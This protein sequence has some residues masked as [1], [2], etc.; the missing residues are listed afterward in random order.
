MQI[1]K[2]IYGLKQAPRAWFDRLAKTLQSFGFIASKCDPSL[3]INITPHATTYVLVYVDDIL[4]TGSSLFFSNSLKHL[5]HKEFA[6]KDLGLLKY[7]LG[8]EVSYNPDGSMHLSQRKYIQD[9]LVKANMHKAKPINTPMV[10]GL[11]LTKQGA[12]LM[13]NPTLYRSI[14]G[15]L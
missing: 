13:S 9:L 2:A 12:N 6:L 1:N 8:I 14:V 3:F 5:L 7:F 10:S 15:A 4:I 11:K